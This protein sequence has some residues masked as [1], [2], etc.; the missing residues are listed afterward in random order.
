MLRVAT[1]RVLLGF[2]DTNAGVHKAH[3]ARGRRQLNVAPTVDHASV[4]FNT[5]REFPAPVACWRMDDARFDFGTSFVLPEGRREFAMLAELILS[6]PRH[7]LSVFS[8]ADSRV[9]DEK[10]LSGRR[11]SA[12]HALLVRDVA[13]WEQLYQNPHASDAWGERQLATMERALRANQAAAHADNVASRRTLFL[14]YMDLL[15][16]GTRLRLGPTDFLGRGALQGRADVQGCSSFNPIVVFSEE[17]SAA[18][19]TASHEE[20]RVAESAP[21]R[22]VVI[23]VF[24]ESSTVTEGGWPCPTVSEDVTGCTRR[25]WSDGALR[26]RPE[27]AERRYERQGATFSCRFYDRLAMRSPCEGGRSRLLIETRLTDPTRT[28]IRFAPFRILHGDDEHV[29][30]ANAD[31]F[32]AIHTLRPPEQLRIE[33]TFPDLEEEEFY[34]YSRNFYTDV[35]DAADSDE[36][37]LDN[38]GF[39]AGEPNQKVAAYQRHFGHTV[40]GRIDDIRDELREFHDGGTRPGTV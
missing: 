23:F 1:H 9:G 29:G 37:R 5:I 36:R 12:I 19:A 8:H 21:N 15:C 27:R 24:P 2:D 34:L 39:A 17:K 31:G 16:G 20:M 4:P 18:L 32:V 25:L 22:R 3:P 28:P 11:A 38:L 6:H 40:T 26:R 33:W 13:A 14:R 35:G 10:V 30:R 7:T